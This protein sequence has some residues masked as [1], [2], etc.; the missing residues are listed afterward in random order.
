[1]GLGLGV[2]DWELRASLRQ[3]KKPS[4]WMG[5]GDWQE[6]L[7]PSHSPAHPGPGLSAYAGPDAGHHLGH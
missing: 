4:E 6:T 5:G 3:E 1:M 2:R 7:M